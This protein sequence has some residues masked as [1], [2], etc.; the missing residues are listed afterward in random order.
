V[1][2]LKEV[3]GFVDWPAQRWNPHSLLVVGQIAVALVVMVCSGL[4]LRNLIR[5]RGVDP[6][7]DPAQVLAVSFEDWT[8]NGLGPEHIRFME[9][10]RTRVSRLPGVKS[11]SL[12]M[13][14]PLG[15]SGGVTRVTHMEGSNLPPGRSVYQEYGVVGPGYFQTLGQSVSA[16]REFTVHDGPEAAKVMIVNEI[17]ARRYWSNESPIG[18]RVTFIGGPE[19]PGEIREII[20]VVQAAKVRSIL[21]ESQP[22]AYVPLAQRPLGLP[23]VLLIRAAGHPRSLIPMLRAEVEA[24]GPPLPCDIR[25]VAERVS[26][27]LLPQRILTVILNLF[28]FVGLWLSATGI[29]AVMAYAVRQRTREIGIRIALGARGQDVVALVLFKGTLLLLLGLGLGVG[30]SLAATRLL[31]SQL[32]RIRQWDKYSLQDISVWDPATYAVA[33]LLIVMVT[34]I[35][36]YLPARRAARIDPMVALRYE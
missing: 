9:D 26:G 5:L 36:C 32:G 18:K 16:G 7:F 25:T 3:T 30:L 35:A 6:G 4:C 1:P 19:K 22:L 24:L 12:S 15:E 33:M 21:E 27:L 31:A 20:G 17:M 28:G 23:P 29:Y 34:L 11:A 10:L 13:T 2:T 14:I 8:F